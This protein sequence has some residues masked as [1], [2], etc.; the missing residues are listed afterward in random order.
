MFALNL[1]VVLLSAQ[2][3]SWSNSRKPTRRVCRAIIAF[4]FES[5]LRR[6][7]SK[8]GFACEAHCKQLTRILEE[9][10]EESLV[11]EFLVWYFIGRAR[12]IG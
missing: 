11:G 4:I 12:D 3:W 9:G 8:D 5:L 6:R 1:D 10:V 2:V 7:F